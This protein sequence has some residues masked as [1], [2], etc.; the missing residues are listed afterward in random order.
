MY[1]YLNV[2]MLSA[3][4]YIFYIC[5]E[6]ISRGNFEKGLARFGKSLKRLEMFSE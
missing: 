2:V 4:T 5:Q 1:L 3:I 6:A